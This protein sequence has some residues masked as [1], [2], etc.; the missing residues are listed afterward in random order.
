M[1]DMLETDLSWLGEVGFTEAEVKPRQKRMT[2]VGSVSHKS[3]PDIS[4]LD[5]IGDIASLLKIRLGHSAETR[6]KISAAHLGKIV[7]AITRAKISE[8]NQARIAAGYVP[9]PV[10]PEILAQRKE[11]R[12]YRYPGGFKMPAAIVE[13]N[14]SR[15][16]GKPM[17]EKAIENIRASA[18]KR[19]KEYYETGVKR[20]PSEVTRAKIS[21]ALL[22]RKQTEESNAKRSAWSS[23]R[24]HTE[25]T[26]AKMS[27]SQAGKFVSEEARENMR[28]AQQRRKD[29]GYVPPAIT[30]E[31]RAKIGAAHKGKVMS[32]ETKAKLRAANLGKKKGPKSPE[33][34]ERMQVAAK[35]RWAKKRA[36]KAFAANEIQ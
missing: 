7:S 13:A 32:E 3:L 30:D 29:S 20:S 24:Q 21:E 36:E 2:G 6:A 26:K 10:T 28:A 1:N 12:E 19:V 9:P 35:A 14:A 4:L 11:T 34:I 18:A 33:T 31:A 25:E 15:R 17:S 27:A 16:R 23:Q 5:G 22:G 8:S